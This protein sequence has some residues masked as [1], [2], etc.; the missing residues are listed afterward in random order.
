MSLNSTKEDSKLVS[1]NV[2]AMLTIMYLIRVKSYQHI[3]N[4]SNLLL[5][6]VI[7]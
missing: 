6:Q 1:V 7:C 5:L 4:L 3:R 2:L